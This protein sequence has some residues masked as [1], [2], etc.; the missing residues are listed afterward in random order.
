MANWLVA[1]EALKRAAQVNGADKD[2]QIDRILASVSV[3]IERE[4]RR[5]FIPRTETRLYPW[6]PR[7]RG[8][9]AYVLRVDQD[10]LSVTTLRTKAQDTSPTT[11]VAADYFLEPVNQTPYDRIEIDLSSTA[12]FDSGDT[13]QRSISVLG[14][15]GF[16]NTTKTAGTVASGLAASATATSMVCSDA[17]L[18]EVGN[19]LLIESEQIFVSERTFAARGAILLDMVGNLAASVATVAVTVDGTHGIV[20]GEVLKIDSEEMFVSSVSVNVLTVIRAFNGTVLASHNNDTAININRTLTIVRG[21]NGTTGAIHADAT[22]VNIYDLPSD[23]VNLALAEA[24]AM[25]HQEGSGW[26]RVQGPGDGA[27]EL[28]GRQLSRLRKET[29]A[30]YKRLIWEAV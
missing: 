24:I 19:T 6:P 2:A 1:R 11:I 27:V 30:S 8:G 21:I 15:W 4:S 9:R 3:R 29:M 16:S 13:P 23:I 7:K 28:D 10:L 5:Y 22:A 12:A 17:S 20:K 26:G 14:S 18:I 25:Y